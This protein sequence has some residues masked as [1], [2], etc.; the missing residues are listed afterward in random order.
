M[1]DT[2]RIIIDDKEYYVPA[3]KNLVDMAKWYAGNDI[4]VFCYHPKMKPAG[5]CR[6]CLVE[7]GTIQKDRQSGEVLLDDDGNPQIRWWPTLQT[8]CTQQTSPKEAFGEVDVSA[9]QS[10]DLAFF[11]AAVAFGL[12]IN[13]VVRFE[14]FVIFLHT[15]IGHAD[16]VAYCVVIWLG[17]FR[18]G[19]CGEV[20]VGGAVHE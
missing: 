17:I 11:S 2:V 15:D 5:V 19:V 4:P 16:A 18:A 6:M 7:M 20:T 9:L 8:A 12:L 10:H 1:I 3:G 14:K 13:G